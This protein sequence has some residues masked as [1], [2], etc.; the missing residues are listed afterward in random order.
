L[1]EIIGSHPEVRNVLEEDQ[2]VEER[3]E[4]KKHRKGHDDQIQFPNESTL[5]FSKLLFRESFYS[6]DLYGAREPCLGFFGRS[7]SFVSS[8]DSGMVSAREA[9]SKLSLIAGSEI[10]SSS[11]LEDG[12]SCEG[13]VPVTA[14]GGLPTELTR[15][16]ASAVVSEA[17]LRDVA[18]AGK[19]P[20]SSFL[21]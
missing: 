6:L 15:F 3:E 12:T 7:A 4:I 2:L 17:S 14:V 13:C 16:A 18:G 20:S 8:V 21:L 11:G 9:R 5:N 19:R 10:F 1:I